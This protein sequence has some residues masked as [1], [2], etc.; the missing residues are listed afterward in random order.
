[1]GGESSGETSAEPEHRA[2]K[3]QGMTDGRHSAATWTRLTGGLVVGCAVAL[4]GC[5]AP[6]DPN[7]PLSVEETR[8]N[9]EYDLARDSFQHGRGR[10]A[11]EHV[12][13]ALKI[14][15]DNADAF[16]LGSVIMLSFCAVDEGSPDC[17]LKEAEDYAR[18]AIK[19]APEHRDSKN[20][21]GV[22]L[23]HE[24]RFDDAIAVL[25][26][27]SEDILYTSPENAW[28]NLGWAYLLQGDSDKALDALQRAVAAQPLFCVGQYR[29]GL[30]YEKKGDLPHAQEAY[31]RTVETNRPECQ[32]LQEAYS[33]RARI[34]AKMAKR[35]EAK[36]DMQKCRDLAPQSR[37][38]R[39]CAQQ[40]LTYQ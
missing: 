34:F 8:S 17:R 2:W 25:K 19:A 35:D 27:L 3:V 32:G 31:T 5:P 12:G 18:K 26:P 36:A 4:T 20:T 29:I 24:H 38:G 6:R 13:K 11:L 7:G 28:G 1:M 37:V 21:L 16:Y 15:S 39:E 30:A 9:G 40:L 22:I 33:A 23:I 10:E 14:K